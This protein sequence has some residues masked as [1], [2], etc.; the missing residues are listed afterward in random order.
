MYYDG[1]HIKIFFYIY[2]VFDNKILM[3]QRDVNVNHEKSLRNCLYDGI[4]IC[5]MMA[6][7]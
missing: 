3:S 1:S 4:D 7:I 2:E 5:I 6:H